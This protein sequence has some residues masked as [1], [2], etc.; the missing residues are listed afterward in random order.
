MSYALLG[1]VD[2]FLVGVESRACAMWCCE[3]TDS[4][5][6]KNTFT[7]NTGE[8]ISPHHHADLK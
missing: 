1:S 7:D 8:S 2:I 3:I 6:I 5:L 4:G